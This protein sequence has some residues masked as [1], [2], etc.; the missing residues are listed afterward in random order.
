MLQPLCKMMEDYQQAQ[1]GKSSKEKAKEV[2][3]TKLAKFSLLSKDGEN[4]VPQQDASEELGDF[5]MRKAT[6]ILHK[7]MAQSVC[8]VEERDKSARQYTDSQ[9]NGQHILTTSPMQLEPTLLDVLKAVQQCQNSICNL[10][11]QVQGLKEQFTFLHQDVQ[12]KRE[13]TS[14]CEGRVKELED[15]SQPLDKDIKEVMKKSDINACKL[16]NLENHLRRNNIRLVGLP[17]HSEG[18][19]PPEFG[20]TWLWEMI[21]KERLSMLFSV[22][23]AHRVPSRPLPAG[24]PPRP[25]LI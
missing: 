25:F 17:E 21:G 15:I 23:R 10:T 1:S 5:C 2:A 16:E 14:A 20:E 24:S 8:D 6:T 22:E 18:A 12:K 4:K 9:L 3:A 7:Y 13:R 11:G 19:I